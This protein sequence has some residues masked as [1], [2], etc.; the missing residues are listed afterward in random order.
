MQLG[1]DWHVAG[2]GGHCESTHGDVEVLI[3]PE[4]HS[5]A[6]GGGFSDVRGGV[7]RLEGIGC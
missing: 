3:G 7:V 2:G 4:P 6:L 5:P 1:G